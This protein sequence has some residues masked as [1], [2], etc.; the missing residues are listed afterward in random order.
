[1]NKIFPI[2]F[3]DNMTLFIEGNNLDVII[4]SLNNKLAKI[5]TNNVSFKLNVTKTFYVVSQH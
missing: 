3:A 1:M 4:T 5:K 2:L